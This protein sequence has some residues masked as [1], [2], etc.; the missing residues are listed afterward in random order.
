MN[1]R[2]VITDD[3]PIARKGLISYIE[4]IDF[5]TLVGECENAIQLN[6]LLMTT[7]VD[8][9]FLDIEMPLISGLDYL[10]S[11]NNPPKVIITSAYEQY[12]LKGYELEVMDYL[13]KPISF[14]RFLKAVNRIHQLL[15]KENIQGTEAEYI[16]VKSD[17]QIK[18]IL[19]DD[20]LFVESMENY[21]VIHT[22]IS[23]EVVYATMKHIHEMLPDDKFI[24]THRSY[25]INMK[26][27][28][29]IDAN[30]LVVGN[31]KLPVSRNLREEVYRKIL[32]NRLI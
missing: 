17:K 28:Q 27:I 13:L 1:I 12:A 22:T 29:S 3:E 23:R 19:L 7:P 10:A 20:I 14:E 24:Q 9:L 31:H 16:F 21:V 25:I 26:H 18:K 5:L 11:L 8:L 2:C 32:K 15:E 6:N 30:L 4:E